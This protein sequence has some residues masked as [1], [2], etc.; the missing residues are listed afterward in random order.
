MKNQP[1]PYDRRHLKQ[2]LHKNEMTD[3]L[4][5]AVDWAKAHL[6][7]VLIG[8]LVLAAAVF[9]AIFFVNGRKAKSLDASMLLNEA[10]SAFQQAGAAP[11]SQ[12]ASA[13]GQAYSKYQ[14]ITVSYA[15]TV[16]AKVAQLGLANADLGLGKGADAE[17]E[18]AA[19]DSHDP[20]DSI[21]ALAG[22]GRARAL[23]L[24]GKP[25]DALTAYGDALR[26]YPD[27]VVADEAR[28]AQQRLAKSA[29]A[30]NLAAKP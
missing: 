25:A 8:V 5:E 18:Y 29:G 11:P 4:V 21:A 2:V 15:G 27:S 9:G 6:E 12:A 20:L 7:A 10:Q 30:V 17:R 14:A 23:E 1:H 16:Q 26:N 22:L 28:A 24:E 3:G 19:L 13:F